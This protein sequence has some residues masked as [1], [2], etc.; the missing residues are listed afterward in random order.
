[1][2]SHLS[3]HATRIGGAPTP[4]V[5]PLSAKALR[6]IAKAIAKDNVDMTTMPAIPHDAPCRAA[7]ADPEDWHDPLR[8]FTLT[9]TRPETRHRL[10]QQRAREMC[11]P[12]PVLAE[13]LIWAL[14]NPNQAGVLGGHTHQARRNLR[15][16]R[17]GTHALPAA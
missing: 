6:E 13:C 4:E 8:N 10:A 17:T 14:R 5:T 2:A 7:D 3:H 16:R 1:M 15:R 11:G 12:C 9:T